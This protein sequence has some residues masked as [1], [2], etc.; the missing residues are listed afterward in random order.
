MDSININRIASETHDGG[1][2]WLMA[3]EDL[4]I[5]LDGGVWTVEHIAWSDD[6]EDWY[7]YYVS[8]GADATGII[9]PYLP[10][11]T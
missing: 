9:K 6:D 2:S 11:Y 1:A 3:D 5:H 10:L 4:I 8:T 7:G